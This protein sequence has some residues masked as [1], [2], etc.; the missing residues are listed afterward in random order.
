MTEIIDDMLLIC[1]C[2]NFACT[3]SLPVTYT[4]YLI[5]RDTYPK[6]SVILPDHQSKGDIV[7]KTGDG[8]LVVHENKGVTE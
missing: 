5:I 3:K 8:F 2:A 4:E 6:A 1:E 7:L